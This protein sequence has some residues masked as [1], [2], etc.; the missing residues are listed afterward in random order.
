M[1][2]RD[3]TLLLP[4]VELVPLTIPASIDAAD[5]GDFVE[6]IRVRNEVYC[7]INGNDD[8]SASP[9]ELLPLFQRSEYTRR[10]WWIVRLDGAAVGRVGIELP[11]ES[12]SRVAYWWIELL[13]RVWGRDIGSAAHAVLERTAREHDR[14][15]LQSWA[16]HPHAGGDR[17]APPTGFGSIPHD[18]AARFMLR[19]GYTLEQVERQSALTLDAAADRRIEGLLAT[20]RR[21]SENYDVVRWMLPTPEEFVDG[22][23]W[24]KS[25]M[26][27][28]APS[29][30]LDV[31]EEEWDAARVRDHDARFVE[32]GRMLQVTAARHVPTGT[33]VAFNELAASTDP[34]RASQQEDTLVL[35]EHRGH[36]LGMR[37][38]C[39]GLV[40]W[41]TVAPQAPRV[42][43]WNAEENRP[44]LDINEAIGF[45]PVLSNGAWKKELG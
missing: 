34:D 12:G 30:D 32:S 44:M 26:S 23:A 37:V 42:L 25:R 38:K 7:E 40:A 16:A 5:A 4:G 1:S 11:Q 39:E 35:R 24:L 17:L 14:S 29:G 8:E 21:A 41:R 10:I 31:D 20:A 27:T 28:D 3:A 33:L 13:R 45:V 18:H 15:I 22:Y 9:A 36:R 19:H 43:T 2:A 6:M